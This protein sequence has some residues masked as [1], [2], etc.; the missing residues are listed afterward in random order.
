MTG[1]MILKIKITILRT[2]MVIIALL[3]IS[4]RIIFEKV[5][6]SA[7]VLLL[8]LLIYYFIEEDL[9]KDNGT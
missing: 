2:V 6:D 1:I 9:N 3:S 4:L 7:M 5:L 8:V